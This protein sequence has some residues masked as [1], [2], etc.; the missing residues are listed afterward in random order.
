MEAVPIKLVGP[1]NWAS[2]AATSIGGGKETFCG[3]FG[4]VGGFG[5]KARGEIVRC[6]D[7]NLCV[8]GALGGESVFGVDAI[9]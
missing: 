1:L 3:G 6:G 5:E 8:N 4:D 9:F 7:D 2:Y